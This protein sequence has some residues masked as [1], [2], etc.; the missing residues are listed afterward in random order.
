MSYRKRVIPVIA[1]A[2]EIIQPLYAKYYDLKQKCDRL[3]S[4]ESDLNDQIYRMRGRL[5]QAK[6]EKQTL[7]NQIQDFNR[8]K[9][10]LGENVIAD[11]IRRAKEY[12]QIQ[13][14]Q[15]IHNRKYS[16]DVR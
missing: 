9:S 16:R 8:V 14:A 11:A 1:K 13:A 12:E 3:T 4:R 2:L 7:R 10:V 15:R 6:E 5:S